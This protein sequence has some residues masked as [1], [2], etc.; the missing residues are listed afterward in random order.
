MIYASPD[1]EAGG[2]TGTGDWK[3]RVLKHSIYSF[4]V[5]VRVH[6]SALTLPVLFHEEFTKQTIFSL[7]CNILH[8]L[9]VLFYVVLFFYLRFLRVLGRQRRN[10]CS[11]ATA[12][13]FFMLLVVNLKPAHILILLAPVFRSI[14]FFPPLP[15]FYRA[16]SD[17]LNWYI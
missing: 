17:V 8:F 15:S 2:S 7:R 14:F 11:A 12:L 4:V 6:V 16:K 10:C 13:L 1:G 5:C 9:V 3:C